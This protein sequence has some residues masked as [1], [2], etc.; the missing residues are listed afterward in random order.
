MLSLHLVASQCL[1]DVWTQSCSL[2]RAEHLLDT[3][4]WVLSVEQDV[5]IRATSLGQRG[6]TSFC[7]LALCMLGIPFASK[8]AVFLLMGSNLNEN[9]C[10]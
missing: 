2:L 1:S 8:K 5:D 6:T 7:M 3:D 10:W 9:A 4:C